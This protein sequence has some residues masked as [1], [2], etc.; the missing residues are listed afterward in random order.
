MRTQLIYCAA[1]AILFHLVLIP[2]QGQ[3]VEVLDVPGGNELRVE[4]D[5]PG[6]SVHLRVDDTD[7][8]LG[9]KAGDDEI[10]VIFR[11]SVP[12][13][14]LGPGPIFSFP[15]DINVGSTQHRY[16]EGRIRLVLPDAVPDPGLRYV[17][18]DSLHHVW[19]NGMG[20][21]LRVVITP[22][23][24]KTQVQGSVEV[25]ETLR[26]GGV[27][28]PQY[29]LGIQQPTGFTYIRPIPDENGSNIESTSNEG[30]T[31]RISLLPEDF[32]I[33]VFG[34][35]TTPNDIQSEGDL[36]MQ[37]PGA[38]FSTGRIYWQDSLL[39]MEAT[40]FSG[41]Q[42]IE[43]NPKGDT[44][45]IR[46]GFTGG[47][48]KIEGGLHVTGDKN[49]LI[50][51]PTDPDKLLVHSCVE[52]PERLNIYSGN[53]VTDSAGYATVKLPDYFNALNIDYRYQLTVLGDS[54][55][56]AIVCK[57]VTAEGKFRIRTD[58]PG[59]KVSWQVSGIRNDAYA[60]ANPFRDVLEQ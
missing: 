37:C 14:D 26:A 56:R 30:D 31:V 5:D 42:V 50:E 40:S 3:Q 33:K 36:I 60:R 55:A 51:H 23:E 20:D 28:L 2:V 58:I 57:E 11:P 6:R 10:Q 27:C 54:F 15:F 41:M 18:S 13:I 45:C 34:D 25:E 43:F 53:V 22:G 8:L 39:R 17:F 9:G 24:Y 32:Q 1:L 12:S 19:V 35:F 16:S 46:P 21:T 49:F 52:A 4:A 47:G 44:I 59:T 48:V 7:L 29:N 38:P